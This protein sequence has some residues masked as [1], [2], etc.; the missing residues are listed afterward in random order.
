MVIAGLDGCTV[1]CVHPDKVALAVANAPDPDELITVS[2]VFRLLGDPTRARLLYALLEVGELCVC[3]LAAATA[4]AESTV[5][6]A[7]R[8]LRASGV[9]AGRREGRN[10][11]YR[12]SDGHVRIMLDMTREHVVHSGH[13]AARDE[14]GVR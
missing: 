1:S 9:V 3:D 4:T 8:M 13:G 6:Q 2:G 7:L 11:F 14:S 10:V 5:S 12:L